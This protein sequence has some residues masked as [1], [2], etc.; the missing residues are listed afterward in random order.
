MGVDYFLES[1]YDWWKH[2]KEL[3]FTSFTAPFF[4][5]LL[6]EPLPGGALNLEKGFP[7][8]SVPRKGFPLQSVTQKGFSLE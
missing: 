4:A 2:Q 5:V 3:N 6:L 1:S 7:L 8:E